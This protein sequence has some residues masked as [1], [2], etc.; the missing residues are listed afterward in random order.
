[1]DCAAVEGAMQKSMRAAASN[2]IVPRK[3]PV[4]S[5]AEKTV[6][7]RILRFLCNTGAGRRFTCVVLTGLVVLGAATNGAAQPVQK[8]VLVLQ[9]VQR[10]NIV[11][12]S[13]TANFHVELDQRAEQPVNFVQVV[14]GPMGSV[15]ASE[16]AIVDFIVSTFA[17][18]PKPD[19]IVAISGP[20]AVFARKYRGQLF[21]DSPLLF[22]A[23]D[24][25]YLRDA[26]LGEN[27]T[28]VAVSNDFPRLIEDILQ[29]LPQTRHVFVVAGTG[30][31]AQFW[32][33]QLE[34]PFTRFRDRLT[35]EWLDNL[36]LAEMLR[37]CASLPDNSAIF[38]LTFG[39]DAAGAEYAET[40]VLADLHATAN[41]PVFGGQSVHLGAGAVG[42]TMLSVDTLASNTADVAFRLLSGAPP[43][44]IKVPPLAP[45]QPVFDWRELE[46][47]A[48][49]E[50][51]LPAGSVV[52]YRAP[53]LWRAYRGTVLSAAGVLAVQSLLIVGL[54]YQ[55]RARQRAETESRRNLELAADASR[56]QTM[57]A[58]TSS[59]AH[60]LGQPLSAMIHNAQ[61]LQMMVSANRAPSDT[62]GEI[63]SDIQAQGAQA[64][65][66]IDRHR[67]MLRSHQ[68]DLKPIDL[69]AVIDESLALVDHEMRTRQ[70][71][72]SVAL[73]SNPCVVSGDPV[74][75][76]QVLV[77]LVINAMD[78]MAETPPARRRVTIST[79]V[80]AADV[81]LSVRDTGTGLPAHINGTLFTA[82]VTTKTRGL[83]IGLT[84]A[85]TIVDAHGGSI[86]AR[87]N[88]EGGATFTVT[89]HRED[90][91]GRLAGP[92]G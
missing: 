48:I 16:Q 77:N 42:G 11:V 37:R 68:L 74:L 82:F 10:G 30:Q 6:V 33:R 78:A 70:I 31:L 4:Y 85:R 18:G 53:S 27:E 23:V 83:G 36:S 54:L 32:R 46:R 2:F 7:G 90:T 41:A 59:I 65:H 19:L 64:T 15:G 12:D 24:W 80:R 14:L 71:E 13:F 25:R 9:S 79:D 75:L 91:V 60:E 3:V 26:P 67:T 86:D 63:L 29:V 72:A 35:F 43:E 84:I 21:P 62:M 39:A 34:E 57:A 44:S 17:N 52:Q 45:G 50:S 40:R 76:Q 51:R 38:Y 55:R 56:R 5:C 20:A 61:A 66:I 1:M 47:W 8:Q 88:P 49:P 28:A 87:N 73:S 92:P 69:H 89:L 22:A 81:A 58:L